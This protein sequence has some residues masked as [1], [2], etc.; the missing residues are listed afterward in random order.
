VF[1]ES[2]DNF[3]VG[4]TSL[5]NSIGIVLDGATNNQLRFNNA[6]SNDTQGIVLLRSANHN[7]L[8]F[9]TANQNAGGITLADGSNSNELRN[10]QATTTVLR[11]SES[12][13][14]TKISLRAISPTKTANTAFWFSEA[15]ASTH[16]FGIPDTEM[17]CLTATTKTQGLGTSGRTITLANVGILT[18]AMVLEI[19]GK[20]LWSP[21]VVH[22]P[23]EGV[24]PAFSSRSHLSVAAVGRCRRPDLPL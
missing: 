12:T 18:L 8:E 1:D 23:R 24:S 4:N 7:L 6:S 3:V 2:H 9:N 5:R 11:G 15:P 16:S 14:Q 19:K 22:G 20:D 21:D 10:N 13:S 17:D